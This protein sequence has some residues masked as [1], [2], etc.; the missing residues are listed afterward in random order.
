VKGLKVSLEDRVKAAWMDTVM[1]I[2]ETQSLLALP[3]EVIA[4]RLM[5]SLSCEGCAYSSY[6]EGPASSQMWPPE[7]WG[8]PDDYD[9]AEIAARESTHIHPIVQYL[10][11]AG[12][13][14]GP[15]Q[16]ADVPER[17][18]ESWKARGFDSFYRSMGV[19]HH[20]SL[21]LIGTGGSPRAFVLGRSAPFTSEEMA[22][23]RLAHR[24]ICAIDRQASTLQSLDWWTDGAPLN[25]SVA[26]TGRQAAV[27]GLVARGMTAAAVGRRLEIS[28]ATV[29]KHLQNTYKKLGVTDRISAVTTARHAGVLPPS[30]SRSVIR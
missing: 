25:G 13:D 30:M 9:N 1:S 8:G 18:H 23:A 5:D 2:F 17:F 19:D 28:E 14:P 3:V 21:P 27:L 20:L 12:G 29:N 15:V 6:G 16:T 26:L 11:V 24:L 10:A 22:A 7:F 4:T